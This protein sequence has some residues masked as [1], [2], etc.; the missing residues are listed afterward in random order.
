MFIL[1]IKLSR[2]SEE[3]GE[4]R[5]SLAVGRKRPIAVVSDLRINIGDW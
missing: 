4:Y 5:P 2:K 1:S 3:A